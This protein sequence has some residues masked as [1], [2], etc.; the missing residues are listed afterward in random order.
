MLYI[1]VYVDLYK[2]RKFS[3]LRG[4]ILAKYYYPHKS[5]TSIMTF[6]LYQTKFYRK[7]SCTFPFSRNFF[8]WT[9]H[10]RL[11][12]PVYRLRVI[13]LDRFLINIKLIFRTKTIKFKTTVARKLSNSFQEQRRWNIRL[14]EMT[15][16]SSL[17]DLFSVLILT[18][19]MSHGSPDKIK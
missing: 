15:K 11:S 2:N 7:H 3:I 17:I 16:T 14:H 9:N 8:V 18:Y 13:Y 6:C 19:E 10:I 5:C 4:L 12:Q 1:C